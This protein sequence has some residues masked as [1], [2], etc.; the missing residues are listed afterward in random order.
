ME[1]M[2]GIPTLDLMW[3]SLKTDFAF[4]LR[5]APAVVLFT[6]GMLLLYFLS[7]QVDRAIRKRDM[8][9]KEYE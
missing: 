4:V 7:C 1:N 3:L 6:I 8:R 9:K 2:D 5:I